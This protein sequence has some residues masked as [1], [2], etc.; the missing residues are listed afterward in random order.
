MQIGR[1][2]RMRKVIEHHGNRMRMLFIDD[3]PVRAWDVVPVEHRPSVYVAHGFDQIQYYLYQSGMVWDVIC[4]DHDMPLLSGPVVC[5]EFLCEGD[6]PV[7]IH[8][9]NVEGSKVMASAL[10]EY[11]V[12]HKIVCVLSSNWW[13]EVMAF[14]SS[15]PEKQQPVCLGA[16]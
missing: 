5:R 10:S 13:T 6:V 14:L 12:P 3:Q 11:Y 4:C 1:N 16:P 7:I 15:L 2:A 9:A 8:S